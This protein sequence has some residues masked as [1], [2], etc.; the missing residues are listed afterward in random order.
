MKRGS[1]DKVIELLDVKKQSIGSNPVPAFNILNS[2]SDV[3]MIGL[4]VARNEYTHSCDT[5]Q[6]TNESS[7]SVKTLKCGSDETMI[8]LAGN[9]QLTANNVYPAL[10]RVN[11]GSDI[12]MF[13][14]DVES[15]FDLSGTIQRNNEPIE[16]SLDPYASSKSFSDDPIINLNSGLNGLKSKSDISLMGLD[17]LCSERSYYY[18]TYHNEHNHRKE[19][20]PVINSFFNSGGT[21]NVNDV[22]SCGVNVSKALE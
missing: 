12:A 20:G 10:N 1:D 13:N 7:A 8:E 19:S 18:D 3:A 5:I 14:L 4:D 2:G 15:R 9:K 21:V 11:S 17:V 22:K 6:Q 16:S